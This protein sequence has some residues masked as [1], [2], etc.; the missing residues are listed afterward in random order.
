MMEVIVSFFLFFCL[1]MNDAEASGQDRSARDAIPFLP[2]SPVHSMN[3]WISAW[4]PMALLAT[5]PTCHRVRALIG[6][7]IHI[8]ISRIYSLLCTIFSTFFS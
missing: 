8:Y 6:L 7:C 3:Q 4:A 2:L 5:K 1:P